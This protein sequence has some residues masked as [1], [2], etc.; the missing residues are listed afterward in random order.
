[1][2]KLS[3]F[4]QH[5]FITARHGKRAFPESTLKA[6][7]SAIADGETRHR[8]EVRLM[9]EPSLPLHEVLSGT[10]PRQRACELFSE[11]RIWDTEENCGILIY[12]NL[13]DH[14]VEIVADRAASRALDQETWESVCQMM[15]GGY[16]Q[17][18]FEASTVA[19]IERLNDL[20]HAAFPD[21]GSRANQLLDHPLI[22]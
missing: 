7:Q 19:A 4:F 8:A 20:L 5:L 10:T 1:M 16:R 11:Y 18:E 14:D 12:I 21:D 17:G 2:N 6:I 15:T 22:L 13:A 9:I 3:R